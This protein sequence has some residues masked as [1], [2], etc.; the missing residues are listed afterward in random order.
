[1][2]T[3]ARSL[4]PIFAAAIS[5]GAALAASDPQGWR[6]A[7]WGMRGEDLAQAFKGTLEPVGQLEFNNYVVRQ[8]IIRTEIGGRPFVVLFQ[9]DKTS[10]K[11]KQVL[12]QF[13]GSRPMHTD[14]VEVGK[15][16]TAELGGA[17]AGEG[18]GRLQ[19][20]LP[21]LHLGN[22]LVLS[23]HRNR[24]ALCRPQCGGLFGPAQGP[25]HPLQRTQW[26]MRLKDP[27]GT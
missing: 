4:A 24:A 5:V 9:L 1:M 23:D 25:C 27:A 13:R 7:R 16:L 2:T 11:L 20:L 6:E 22:A 17:I 10:E 19:R 18:P 15:A 26:K 12:L 8:R 3:I 14:Y 21:L